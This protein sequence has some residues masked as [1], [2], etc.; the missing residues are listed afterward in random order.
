MNTGKMKS[1]VQFKSIA[2]LS[3]LLFLV[4]ASVFGASGIA[5]KADGDNSDMPYDK[6]FFMGF[7]ALRTSL[8]PS[9]VLTGYDVVAEFNGA[10]ESYDY[11]ID[12]GHYYKYGDEAY[13][14]SSLAFLGKVEVYN[15][16]EVTPAFLKETV[17]ATTTNYRIKV[18]PNP[19]QQICLYIVYE[20][21]PLP[22]PDAPVKAG[23]TF[24]GWY[25]DEELTRPYDG[26]PIYTDAHLVF[27]VDLQVFR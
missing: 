21:K 7:V 8:Y 20:Q 5:A 9:T 22:L 25:F 23:H 15:S 13:G 17:D 26:S 1:G 3:M 27:G 18:E 11:Y 4:L 6:S 16:Y 2:F 19:D 12:I 24:V 14:D 10:T